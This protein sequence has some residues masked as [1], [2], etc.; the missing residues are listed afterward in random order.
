VAAFL[1][2]LG[3]SLPQLNIKNLRANYPLA[4]DENR[5]VKTAI[6]KVCPLSMTS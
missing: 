5:K 3:G 1:A 6:Q 2:L 4:Y